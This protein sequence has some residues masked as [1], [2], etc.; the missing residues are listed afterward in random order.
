MPKS[1]FK[2]TFESPRLGCS[3]LRY[4]RGDVRH[5]IHPQA[6]GRI[7]QVAAERL[8]RR[9]RHRLSPLYVHFVSAENDPAAVLNRLV[10]PNLESLK[11][12]AVSIHPEQLREIALGGVVAEL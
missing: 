11:R 2:F 5:G 6:V 9:P 4:V 10:D 12:L 3:R 1:C 7:T 8:Q